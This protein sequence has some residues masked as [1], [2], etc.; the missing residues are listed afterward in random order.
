[1]QDNI[2]PLDFTKIPWLQEDYLVLLSR[3]K[4]NTPTH[5]L[6]LYVKEGVGKVLLMDRLVAE[7]L[8]RE[9]NQQQPCGQCQSCRLLASGFHPDLQ[10][11]KC[12]GEIKV[13]EIRSIQQFARLTPE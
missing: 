1:M 5:A 9:L 2:T 11:I 13:D 4:S 7:I 6:M 12:D 10:E 3:F 8:Y